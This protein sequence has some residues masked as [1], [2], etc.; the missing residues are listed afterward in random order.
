[1]PLTNQPAAMTE[2]PLWAAPPADTVVK[3]ARSTAQIYVSGASKEAGVQNAVQC[4]VER[5][6]SSKHLLEFY[7]NKNKFSP[8]LSLHAFFCQKI[9]KQNKT[10]S[11]Q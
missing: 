10:P 8:Q 2:H 5:D 3:R 6:M 9:K 7:A 4:S 11:T 1:M